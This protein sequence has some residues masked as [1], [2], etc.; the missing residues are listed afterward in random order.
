MEI[1]IK[2]TPNHEKLVDDLESVEH[3]MAQGNKVAN[4]NASEN[5]L[6]NENWIKM[7]NA[8]CDNCKRR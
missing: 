3:A 2:Y 8:K 4:T 5:A 1:V 7:V 6:C